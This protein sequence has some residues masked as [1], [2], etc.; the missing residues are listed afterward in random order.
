MNQQLHN[1][2]FRIAA[3]D[4]DIY[5]RV[6]AMETT[7]RALAGGQI[8]LD[9]LDL[10]TT[11]LTPQVLNDY[12]GLLA[13][14]PHL[15][16]A[17]IEGVERCAAIVRYGA[18]FDRIDLDACTDADIML[19]TTPAGIRRPLAT[20]A[21][22]LILALATRLL[23]K[24]RFVYHRQWKLGQS[25]EHAGAGLTGKTIGY[26]G[27]GNVGSELYALVQPFGMKH[28]V[29]DPYLS[30][31]V[32]AQY[33]VERVELEA[34]MSRADFVVV[35]C[36]LTDE[37]RHLIGERQLRRMK[38]TAYITNVA[39]GPIIDQ[40]ALTR[41]LAENQIAG[42]GLDVLETEPVEADDP[43]L[44]LDNVILT[45]H[46]MC[47]TDEMIA[48]CSQQCIGAALEVMQGRVPDSVTWRK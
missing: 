24:R 18:G 5:D 16:R 10:G 46:G 28:V 9:R 47:I 36:L 30:N 19:V 39:R 12:D 34:L 29:Y 17:S 6:V 38:P 25:S 42:A 41:A 21:L 32:L 43:I 27:F 37:T 1:G 2:R 11:T 44:K 48:G 40:A 22:T 15:T 45:P 3:T 35:L 4:K 31:E 8:E 26:V 14:G 13:G 33:D 7:Q 23:P 20:S